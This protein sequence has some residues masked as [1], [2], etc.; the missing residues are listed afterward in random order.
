[1]TSMVFKTRSGSIYEV[2]IDTKT[3][4]RTWEDVPHSSS[5]LTGH[6]VWRSYEHLYVRWGKPATITWPS[7]AVTIT[8]DVLE[9]M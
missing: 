5:R 4:C 2:D 9:I 3:I 6:N 1:M 7:G 8:S